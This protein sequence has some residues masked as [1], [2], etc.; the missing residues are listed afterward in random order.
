MFHRQIKVIFKDNFI[1]L[2]HIFSF[3][4]NFVTPAM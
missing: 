2:G 4:D 1:C 3:T